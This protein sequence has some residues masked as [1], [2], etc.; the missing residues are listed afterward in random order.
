[1]VDLVVSDH[2]LIYMQLQELN[3]TL[4]PIFASM[5]S[6]DIYSIAFRDQLSFADRLL[7]N[8]YRLIDRIY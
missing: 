6:L 5:R 7:M 8:V 2:R 4:I 1:M 3:Q